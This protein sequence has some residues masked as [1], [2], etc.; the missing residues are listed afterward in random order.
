MKRLI[1][2]LLV[3]LKLSVPSTAGNPHCNALA[4]TTAALGN[5]PPVADAGADQVLNCFITALFLNGTA[6]SQGG[7]SYIWTTQDGHI[8]EGETTPTPL[9]NAA[10][11]YTLTVTDLADGSTASDEVTVTQQPPISVQTIDLQHVSCHRTATGSA[12]VQGAG[13]SGVYSYTWS[14]GSLTATSAN[15]V[16]GSYSV[17]V[18]DTD[19]C[20]ASSTLVVNEPAPL[21]ANTSATAQSLFGVNDG[22]AT[23]NPTGGTA[24]YSFAWNNLQTTQTISSLP[25]GAISVTITDGKG[26]TFSETTNVNK[27]NCVLTGTTTVTQVSCFGGTDGSISV[28]LSNAVEPI[29]YNLPSSNSAVA[30]SLPVGFYTVLVRDSTTCSL[31]FMVEIKQPTQVSA[32][33]L[34]HIDALCPSDETGSVTVAPNGGVQPYQY[35]WSNGSTEVTASGLS[36]GEHNV[37]L[38]DGN[39]CEQTLTTT[40]IARRSTTDN[41]GRGCAYSGFGCKRLGHRDPRPVR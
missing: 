13:G 4:G 17:T 30:D 22:T 24:P 6:S 27:F 26:C 32:A 23:A 14:N 33:E 34:F 5:L 31:L 15:L 18:S 9:V 1:I 38:T 25:P 12:T 40:I 3:I 37:T 35:L 36:V 11:T 10:G 21:A 2:L 7:F 16:A 29:T 41:G 20:A 28:Q 19:G 8:V 39:G